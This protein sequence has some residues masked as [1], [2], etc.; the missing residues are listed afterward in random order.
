M[1]RQCL[2]VFWLVF[3]LSNLHVN[4]S[5]IL[6]Q[7]KLI[8]FSFSI[9]FFYF[10]FIPFLFFFNFWPSVKKPTVILKQCI[11][12]ENLFVFFWNSINQVIIKCGV[13]FFFAGGFVLT[14]QASTSTSQDDLTIPWNVHCPITLKGESLIWFTTGVTCGR[15][16]MF[17]DSSS[18]PLILVHN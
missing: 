4:I 1:K 16:L 10:F 6:K 11:L 8:F 13:F 5:M 2:E 14:G 17:L 3:F 9:I 18:S 12:I 7:R 15:I